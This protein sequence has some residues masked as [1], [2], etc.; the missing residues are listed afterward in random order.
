MEKTPKTADTYIEAIS[1]FETICTKF[2]FT[3]IFEFHDDRMKNVSNW[4]IQ[5]SG[6]Y[7][8]NRF[9]PKYIIYNNKTPYRMIH[10]YRGAISKSEPILSIPTVSKLCAKFHGDRLISASS[11]LISEFMD[12]QTD[13]HMYSNESALSSTSSCHGSNYRD[14][15]VKIFQSR[16]RTM[17]KGNM[18]IA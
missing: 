7:N 6:S 10:I 2:K 3:P 8:L 18:I 9:V 14:S 16:T 12:G 4:M 1:G 13:G 5:I 17:V 11:T 15:S